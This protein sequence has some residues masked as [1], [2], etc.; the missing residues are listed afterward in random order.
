[1]IELDFDTVEA[2]GLD[3]TGCDGDPRFPYTIEKLTREELVKLVRLL[4]RR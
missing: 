2:L 3:A 1:M 4:L